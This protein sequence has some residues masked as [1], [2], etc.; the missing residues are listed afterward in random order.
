MPDILVEADYTDGSH[1]ISDGEFDA[2]EPLLRSALAEAQSRNLHALTLKIV[3]DLRVVMMAMSLEKSLEVARLQIDL[4]E[5]LNSQLTI[6][7]GV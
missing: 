4:A 3:Q 1:Y 6:S 2:A 5:R 7:D